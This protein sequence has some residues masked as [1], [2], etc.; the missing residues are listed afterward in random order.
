MHINRHNQTIWGAKNP[1][2][3]VEHV[4]DSLKIN[5]FCAMSASKIYEPFFFDELTLTQNM[6][7]CPN[8]LKI[9]DKC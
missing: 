5:V 8:L 3:F 6:G 2:A 1:H 9:L 7:S 4:H